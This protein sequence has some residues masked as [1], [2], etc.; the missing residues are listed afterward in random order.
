MWGVRC[1]VMVVVW[2]AEEVRHEYLDLAI[3]LCN[4][5]ERGRIITKMDMHQ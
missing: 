2:G 4:N 1:G 5:V 3:S